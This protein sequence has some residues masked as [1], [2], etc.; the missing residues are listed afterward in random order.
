MKSDILSLMDIFAEL[1]RLYTKDSLGNNISFTVSEER[2]KVSVWE[3]QLSI[4][5][6]YAYTVPNYENIYL[7]NYLIKE[8]EGE[9]LEIKN[10]MDSVIA[11]GYK[12]TDTI[13]LGGSGQKQF[14]SITNSNNE[15][16]NLLQKEAYERFMYEGICIQLAEVLG[17]F[18]EV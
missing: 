2:I 3:Q 12:E 15:S 1:N 4:L 7:L 11:M 8:V 10:A 6:N 9:C 5:T 13:R 17:F 16:V 14:P 18:Y